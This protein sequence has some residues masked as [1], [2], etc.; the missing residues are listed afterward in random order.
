MGRRFRWKH[1]EG[2][3]ES[4]ASFTLC[5]YR[6]VIGGRGGV[7]LRVTAEGC[8]DNGQA[9]NDALET[10]QVNLLHPGARDYA[11]AQRRQH[12][13]H[14]QKQRQRQKEEKGEP[15]GGEGMHM[16]GR[17]EEG[18]RDKRGKRKTGKLDDEG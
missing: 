12:Y 11:V 1:E 13:L 15:E 9:L 4:K 17:G 7:Y 6:G 2:F 8:G 3:R 10:P 18:R 16:L 14:H 5:P